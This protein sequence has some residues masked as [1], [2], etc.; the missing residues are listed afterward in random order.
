MAD[1]ALQLGKMMQK[2]LAESIQTEMADPRLSFVSITNVKLT[3]DLKLARVYFSVFGGEEKQK[4]A[5]QSLKR[6]AGFLKRQLGQRIRLRFVPEL[7]FFF[8]DSLDYALKIQSLIHQV[9][10]DEEQKGLS[11]DD[12]ADDANPDETDEADESDDA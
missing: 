10:T 4:E 2:I 9:K 7:T 8:D 3:K 5:L 11:A 6:A 12:G 1:R